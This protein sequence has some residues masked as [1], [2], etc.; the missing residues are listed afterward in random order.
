[1]PSCGHDVGEQQ[2]V[3]Q[4]V[5]LGQVA[6]EADAA[7]LFAAHHDLALQHVIADVLEADAVLVSSRPCLAQMRSSIL[8]VLKARV[9]SPGQPLRLSTQLQQDGEDLVRID[10]F[11]V[12]VGG[13]DAVRVAVGAEASVALVGDDRFAEGADV[14]LDGFGIDAGK[15]RI[16]VAANLH[17]I[18]ADARED[19][20]DEWFRRR[21]TSSRWRTS[22]RS[23]R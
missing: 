9:T 17:V 8:V 3:E 7:R 21:R 22:C 10:K 18:D 15:Q 14:R 6:L 12:L 13:A 23:G 20:G 16:D 1:L 2:R 11:A 19:V 5:A 4:A